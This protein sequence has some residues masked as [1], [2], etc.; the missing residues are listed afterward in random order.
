MSLAKAL[1]TVCLNERPDDIAVLGNIAAVHIRQ[2]NFSQAL[3]YAQ[4]GLTLEPAHTKCLYRCGISSMN[5]ASYTEAVSLL[6]KAQQ[7]V[8]TC[9][10]DDLDTHFPF[11]RNLNQRVINS[12]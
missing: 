9:S 7:Q 12:N 8:R 6:E 3:S 4:H 1:Y 10:N 2:G 5:L 11:Q